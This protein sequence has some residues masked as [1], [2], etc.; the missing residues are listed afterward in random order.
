MVDYEKAIKRPFQDITKLV[1][2]VVLNIIPIV[3][4]LVIGYVL[5]CAKTAMKK[6]Y[7]LPEWTDWLNLF[8]RGFIVVIIGLIYMLPFLI[9]MFT[10]A[11]SLVLTM[12][13]GGSFSADIGWTG[14][15]IAFVLALIAYYLLPAAIMEYVKEDFKLGAAFFKFNEITKRTFDRNYLIV[16]L[17]MVVYSIVL[18][19]CLSLIPVIGTAIGSFI[20]SVTA[21]TLFGEL[22]ST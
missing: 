19:I 16:W 2:G 22:Y 5:N 14:M 13:K 10:I 20:A 15:I 9:V 11:G 21:M 18:T 17:F 6:D 12:I 1:I 8:I 7:T 4:F 3:N